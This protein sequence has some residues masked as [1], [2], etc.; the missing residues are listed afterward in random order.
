MKA[1]IE[2]NVTVYLYQQFTTL[3]TGERGEIITYDDV[4]AD[5]EKAM[6]ALKVGE[7]PNVE[8]GIAFE[9]MFGESYQFHI[10]YDNERGEHVHEIR[11]ETRIRENDGWVVKYEGNRLIEKKF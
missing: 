3:F 4:I 1:S 2:I 10:E 6:Q 7:K 9:S 5:K 8:D 11:R